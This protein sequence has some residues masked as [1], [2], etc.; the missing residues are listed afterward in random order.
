L[1]GFLIKK[2]I[3]SQKK[4]LT[5][6]GVDAGLF[7]GFPNGSRTGVIGVLFVEIEPGV[8]AYRDNPTKEKETNNE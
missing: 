7:A 8:L 4:I 3:H 5:L 6:P 1:L 2:R